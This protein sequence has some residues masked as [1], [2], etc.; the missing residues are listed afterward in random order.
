MS[1]VTMAADL[2]AG[3]L[4]LA[5]RSGQALDAGLMA[6]VAANI[7]VADG[8]HALLRTQLTTG[9]ALAAQVQASIDKARTDGFQAVAA[10]P[11]D[12][13]PASRKTLIGACNTSIQIVA[14]TSEHLARTLQSGLDTVASRIRG[15]PA[16]GARTKPRKA[17]PPPRAPTQRA[18]V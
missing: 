18:M 3:T 12:Y 11:G 5:S 8:V 1:V 4:G 13:L 9:K 14:G 10:A 7:A 15:G 16:A 6:L 17:L 2:K